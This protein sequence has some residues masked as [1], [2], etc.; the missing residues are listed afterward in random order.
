[1][2]RGSNHLLRLR[3][4]RLVYLYNGLL[5]L[6]PNYPNREFIARLRNFH[7]PLQRIRKRRERRSTEERRPKERLGFTA[8]SPE[9]GDA[10]RFLESRK[11]RL[12]PLHSGLGKYSL[13]S[14]ARGMQTSRCVSGLLQQ[15]HEPPQHAFSLPQFPKT[16]RVMT[17]CHD[18]PY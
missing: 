9:N 18:S 11:Y 14:L 10:S 1:M 15:L 5:P 2:H 3:S 6:I 13:R 16:E 8:A 12:P 17:T 4:W 7:Q